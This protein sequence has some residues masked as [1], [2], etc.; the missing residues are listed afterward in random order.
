MRRLGPSLAIEA[1][2]VELVLVSPLAAHELDAATDSVRARWPGAIRVLRLPAR[3]DS[4]RPWTLER[5]LGADDALGPALTRVS[6]GRGPTAVRLRRGAP[7][8]ADTAFA[9]G[10]GALVQWD[11]AD[12]SRFGPA[13]L[14]MGDDVVVATLGR[15][16]LP[17]RG[18]A[19]ARWADGSAAAIEE[20][21]DAGCL[22]RVAIGV[23]DA[24]D[25]PLRPAFQRVVRG[26]MAPCG[27]AR[28]SVPADSATVARL[29]GSGSLAAAGALAGREQRSSPLVPW[30]LGLALVCAL[31]ELAI[32][33]RS[34][35]ELA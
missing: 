12:V 32:R 13:A 20:P 28:S 16:T 25:L 15:T 26:L 29:S 9:R 33:A 1:D 34:S 21:L 14:A 4:A 22:R 10:G 27:A 31:A 7:T 30:L 11:S 18:R 35:E 17:A 5:V 19:I 8:A 6:V 2:S 3:P 23:P 24:G